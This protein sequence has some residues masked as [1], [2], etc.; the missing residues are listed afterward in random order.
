MNSRL[1]IKNYKSILNL[2]IDLGQFNVFIGENG[3]GK[4]N[5]LEAVA[6]LSAAK[7]NDLSNDSLFERGIR[8]AKPSLTFSS[9]S[10]IKSK[11][12]IEIEY[13]HT[14]SSSPEII[15][16]VLY[17]ESPSDIYSKWKDR[18]NEEFEK[19]F[20]D[21]LTTQIRG[22]TGKSVIANIKKE[23]GDQSPIS[24]EDINIL[25]K[26]VINSLLNINKIRFNDTIRNFLIYS[27]NSNAL[28]GITNYSKQQPLGIFG[29]GID[30]LINNF[31][32]SE[33]SELK[34][35]SSLI[36]WLK[37]ISTDDFD[38]LK[39]YGY[40]LGRSSSILYFYD[41]YMKKGNNQFSAENANEGALYLLFY[42]SLFISNKT[43]DFFAIDNIETALNPK[44]CR[45][46]IK[47]LTQLSVEKQKQVLVTTHNPAVLDGLNLN[48]QNQRLFVVKR[49]DEGDTRIERITTK[50]KTD[51]SL[52]LSE[53]WMR[54]YLG[55]LSSSNF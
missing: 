2:Q 13:E 41:K 17:N 53:L 39:N 6:L 52:K 24:E 20:K 9:F 27:V 19:I 54:G 34:R 36:G 21:L 26:G 10:K 37:D 15:R 35:H 29:E 4:S 30:V 43:P 51:N 50:P 55:G 44:L 47:V 12:I 45:D 33:K 18:E 46:L 7:S 3:C 32:D 40:K 38:V 5:I 22:R 49:S 28:R 25:D 1:S 11:D 48:D 16:S 8:I 31:T 42:I 14:N 23:I